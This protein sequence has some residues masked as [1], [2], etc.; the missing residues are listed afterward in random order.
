VAVTLIWIIA[1]RMIARIETHR[2]NIHFAPD[3]VQRAWV[4][5]CVD[6]LR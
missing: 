2:F 1:A 3:G 6:N 5:T 4:D